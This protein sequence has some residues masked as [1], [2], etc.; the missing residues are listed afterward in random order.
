M[1]DGFGRD[2]IP[3]V[4]KVGRR[5]SA[6]YRPLGT[7]YD[8]IGYD[9]GTYRLRRYDQFVLMSLMAGP[10]FMLP[11][12]APART[13][14]SSTMGLYVVRGS[15]LPSWRESAWSTRPGFSLG[16]GLMGSAGAHVPRV[17]IRWHARAPEAGD[18]LMPD[19]SNHWLQTAEAGVGA[20]F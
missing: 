6:A 15:N 11:G 4:S 16:V 2:W 10:T 9:A 14:I 13:F 19:A 12:P 17:D 7:I 1:A 18:D 8:A 20:Q 5:V 3:S